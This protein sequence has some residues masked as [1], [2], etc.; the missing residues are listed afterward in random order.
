MQ[1]DV[2]VEGMLKAEHAGAHTIAQPNS[3]D[4]YFMDLEETHWVGLFLPEALS[5]ELPAPRISEKRILCDALDL[6]EKG[7]RCVSQE[8]LCTQS[9]SNEFLSFARLSVRVRDSKTVLIWIRIHSS[10]VH[11]WHIFFLLSQKA[12]RVVCVR[13]V[14]AKWRTF[15][16]CL[17]ER[18]YF[19]LLSGI[20]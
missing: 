7:V 3:M 16:S 8:N 15:G 17:F 13:A 10:L 11:S 6:L 20:A 12:V 1:V 19:L 18:R 5:G 14:N 4:P 2:A 9:A